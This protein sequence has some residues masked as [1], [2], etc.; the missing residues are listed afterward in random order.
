VPFND[1]QAKLLAQFKHKFL[2]VSETSY[3][4]LGRV[5]DYKSGTVLVD[6]ELTG[7]KILFHG[8]IRVSV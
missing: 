4:Y 8:S 3:G 7:E 1:D 6:N 5:G 2:N